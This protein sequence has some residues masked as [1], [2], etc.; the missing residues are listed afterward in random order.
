MFRHVSALDSFSLFYSSEKDSFSYSQ[1]HSKTLNLFSFKSFLFVVS[2]Q[3]GEGP[4][5][6]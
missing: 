1:I 5:R 6:T 2:A 3:V 4:V